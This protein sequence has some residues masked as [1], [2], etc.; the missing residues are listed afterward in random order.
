MQAD[1]G[2]VSR[3]FGM[4]AA[5]M[6]R[7]QEAEQHVENALAM[8]TRMHA[9]PWLAHTQY[10]Y[11]TMLQARNHPGDHEK[12]VFRLHE[13]L[14]TARELGMCALEVRMTVREEAHPLSP[15]LFD[16]DDLS[17]REVAALRLIAAGKSNQ[18]MADS[19][20]ISLNTVAT[21][22]H[23]ILAKT[24]SAN[25]TEAAA[26]AMRCGMVSE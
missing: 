10:N 6:K 9:R 14:A 17:P 4:L 5:T 11:A 12:A 16:I 8:N 15:M 7:W 3:Y 2:A 21:H 22:V 26:Y 23:N 19:L 24:S 20:P 13:A 1:Y 25:R 18:D